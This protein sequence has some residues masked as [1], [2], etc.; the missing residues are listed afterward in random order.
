MKNKQ[1]LV[2]ISLLV[3]FASKAS[4]AENHNYDKRFYV[5]P[6]ISHVWADADRK[7]SRNNY[8]ASLGLGKALSENFNVE[9]KAFYNKLDNRKKT[10]VHDEDRWDTFGSTLDLQYYFNRED[11]SPYAVIGAGVMDSRV[12]GKNVI[13]LIGE[14]GL[15]LAYKVNKY[16]SL[17]SDVRY[18]HNSNLNQHLTTNNSDEYGDMII[19]VGLVIPF[20]T[21]CEGDCK[22]RPKKVAPEPM[23]IINPDLDGDGVLNA[24]DKC[25]NT[26]KNM[27]VNK[28]GC[29][30]V[31][32]LQGVNFGISSA[33]LT[34]SA[35]ETLTKLVK[36]I[37]YYPNS[38][39]IEIQGHASSDGDESFNMKLSKERAQSVANY[40]RSQ[41]VENHLTA[42]GYGETMLIADE[43]EESGLLTNRRVDLFWN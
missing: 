18:R 32:I 3:T 28:S 4:L 9:L 33:D 5:A 39:K 25:P 35:K 10:A 16:V 42:K 22:K 43:F 13:G 17:R 14:A 15:G 41:G 1:L 23:T 11:L 27:R 26:K 7:T 34:T 38:K 30:L 12:K 37:K 8:G 19:N 31:I 2:A 36:E 24:D 6:A 20:G 21:V 29:D 40:L